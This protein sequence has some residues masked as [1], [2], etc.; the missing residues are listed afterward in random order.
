VGNNLRGIGEVWR[1]LNSRGVPVFYKGA[2]GYGPI[3]ELWALEDTYHAGNQ[4]C[5]RL[6][7]KGGI[8][9]DVPDWS[10][11]TPEE[12]AR[13]HVDLTLAYLPPEFDK[14]TWL[15][16]INEPDK[17]E[18]ERFPDWGSAEFAD[19]LGRFAQECARL[20]VPRGYK[21][22]AFGFSS[23]EPEIPDWGTPGM[24]GYLEMCAN[25]PEHVAIAVH[26][27]SYNEDSLEDAAAP[28]PWLLGRFTFIF[29]LCDSLGLN[30]PT[31]L[32]T[33]FG[34]SL[35][36]IPDTG[37]AVD[38]LIW[39]ANKIY[40]PHPEVVFVA[41]WHFGSGFS[42]IADQCQPLIAPMGVVAQTWRMEVED[43]PPPPPPPVETD[44][45]RRWRLS[46]EEQVAHGIQLAPTALQNA[47]R[48]AG[49]QP[50]IKEMF[51]DG[52]PPFLAAE[53]FVNRVK[54]RRVFEWIGGQ[55][56]SYEDPGGDPPPPPPWSPFKLST[57]PVYNVPP[58]VTQY[59]N[60]NVSY[61]KHEGL[62][63]RVISPSGGM[64]DIVSGAPNG[65]VDAIRRV[66]PGNGYGKYVRVVY[67]G[68]EPGIKWV[69][70]YCHLSEVVAGLAVGMR[71]N[72]GVA[73]GV[74]GSTGNSTGP[75]LHITVQK[76]PGGLSGYVRPY[77]VNP[78][79]LIEAF[80]NPP[81]PPPPSSID[82]LPYFQPPGLM[83]P[84]YEVRDPDGAQRRFQT[85]TEGS[86]FFITKGT[87]GQ[88]GKAEWEELG[89]DSE[90]IWRGVDTSPGAGRFYVQ[91][92]PGLRMAKWCKRHMSVGEFWA[93]GGHRVQFFMKKTCQKSAPNSGSH[94]NS[95]RFVA[96]HPFKDWL[97]VRV[98]DVVELLAG[99]ERFFFAKNIGLVAWES[100]WNSSYISEMHQPGQ[101]PNSTKEPICSFTLP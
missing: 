33:E 35:W 94:T 16:L 43:E 77:V 88:D 46:V 76:I 47:T 10:A 80:D 42:N 62:D 82:L 31:I 49:L 67:E 98:E 64:P 95:I 24:L 91:F 65:V 69:V 87:G 56:V 84:L 53:D 38:Q 4:A 1:D 14:R 86:K 96:R 5:F 37:K 41:I 75:H 63:V 66:D 19:W 92:E 90:Y 28:Y 8:K 3:N 54:P 48:A 55:V 71:V 30:R 70:W 18:D 23:G 52:E 9:W 15:E 29:D 45:Q 21:F 25:D 57:Y 11:P 12:A 79:P 59:F 39:A 36:D 83:G 100:P 61:G 26:E 93:G 27:Y 68:F 81:P 101:R 44:R 22:A 40:G 58:H 72:E 2:D 50:V 34:W 73:L 99:E 60:A 89:H 32:V 6:S 13:R 85:Q 7:A 74:A 97:G 20:L 51:V 17:D 78:F